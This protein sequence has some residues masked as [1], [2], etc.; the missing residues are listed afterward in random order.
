MN[1]TDIGRKR[2]LASSLLPPL[3]KAISFLGKMY[4]VCCF[5]RQLWVILVSTQLFCVYPSVIL[6]STL[7]FWSQLRYFI[8][9]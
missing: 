3:K 6:A 5:I 9:R 7:L 1:I 8:F 2:V 4:F